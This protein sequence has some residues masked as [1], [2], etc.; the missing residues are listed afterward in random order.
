MSEHDYTSTPLWQDTL[1][2]RPSGDGQAEQRERLRTSYVELRR[3]AAVLLKEN[4]RSM[5]DFTVHDISHVDAL[6]ETADLVCGRQVTLNPAEAYVLGCAFV[7]HDAA[8]GAAAYRTSVRDALGEKRWRDLVSVEYYHRKGCWP[9]QRA[10]NAPPT[11]IADACRAT[12]IRE[13]HAEQAR[14][15][16]DQ[17]WRSSTGNEIFLIE[18]V[19]LREVYGPLIGD[20]AASHWWPVSRLAG[21]FG[22]TIGSLP[23][24]PS[25]W[26]IDPLKLA[27]VLRLADATQ[28]DSRRAPTLLFSLRSPRGTAREH[29]RFQEHISRPH[30]H[31]DRVRYTS[32]RPFSSRNATS[33]WLAL[34][35]LRDIDAELKSVD[36][37]LHD[38]GRERLAARAVAGVDSPERFAELF[39]V[40]GWRPIDATVKVTDVPALVKSLGGE[41]LY[42]D[43]P[44]VAVRELIQNAQDAVQARCSL[45]PGFTDG[46]IEV[47]LTETGENWCLEICDNGIG[48]DEETLIHGLLD[49]GTSGW[50]SPKIRNA[51][52]GL[53]DGGFQPGGRF[54]IG[55]FSVF[56]LGDRVELT[57][58]RYDSST[59][60]ARR[61][62]FDG[63]T[64]RPLLTPLPTA[65]W[66]PEGT[67]VRVTLKR[68]PN[69]VKGLLYRTED[70]R[71]S[72]LVRRLALENAVPIHSWEP[73][74]A[75]PDIL[76]PFSL[77][78]GSP[79]EVFDRLYPPDP[80]NRRVGEE[81]QRLQLRDEFIGRATE[82]LDDNGRRI[83][84]A[85]LWKDMYYLS[86]R[87][88]QGVVTVNGLLAD[89]SISFSG[90]LAGRPSR[91]SRDRA[92][93]IANQDQVRLWM[94]RQE[95]QLRGN[96]Q[97][98]DAVQLELAHTLNN[99]FGELT[100]DIA[101]AL[102][103]EGVLRP[104]DV[105]D[106]AAGKNEVFMAT[107]LPLALRSRP[108]EV[109]HYLSGQTVRLPDDWIMIS[110][111][112]LNPPLN[113][114]F[115][116][117]ANR[118]PA[119]EYARNDTVLTW[120]KEWWRLSGG[121]Y[122]VFLRALC[123]TWACTVES[124][125]AP[126]EQRNWSDARHLNKETPAS[127][128]G[129]LLTRPPT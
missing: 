49:F 89:E 69:D 42:G 64:A 109:Y 79:E 81:K 20:L 56:L 48:M 111:W 63:P 121:L 68:S 25:E 85:T 67:T 91:A 15:L 123:Q 43:E 65:D 33:W 80:D 36:S 98:G 113:E 103:A 86:R 107:G 74:A 118:D 23:W 2:P 17:P 101:F 92:G 11:E 1:A 72:Q 115:P 116:D 46:R 125:L 40:Q 66:V 60:D 45:Q 50:S 24:Q 10:L 77:A 82:L 120:Q 5:P 53:A 3:K 6:W 62:A 100:S 8:M 28:I 70:D 47:R 104:A 99:A 41:Q 88:F 13:T 9:D 39:R 14:R 105:V 18:E 119:Y 122:G 127:I 95:E 96:G 12:A 54:G 29:W 112:V 61:L 76:A 38:L 32:L 52:P 94:R 57:T 55:F 19:Q 4:E 97:F 30:L 93:L 31:G 58:R 16:V 128:S 35:Y 117:V 106:W 110:V 129:Y 21:E 51:L 124:L 22:H 59:Q 78:A 37:L 90:Y 7:L 108:P 84:L 75:A 71:L 83:G 26:T 34:G 27:C 73:G 102:T 87:N 44:E 114:V 126:V